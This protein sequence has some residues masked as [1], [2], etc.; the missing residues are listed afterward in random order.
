MKKPPKAIPEKAPRDELE[1]IAFAVDDMLNGTRPPPR[2]FGYALFVFELGEP[3][4]GRV[5]YASN[6]QR[7]QMVGAVRQWL[8]RAEAQAQEIGIGMTDD[9]SSLFPASP[10]AK[11]RAD[12]AAIGGL[13]NELVS[14]PAGPVRAMIEEGERLEAKLR[15]AK[16]PAELH[17]RLC[18]NPVEIVGDRLHCRTCGFNSTMFHLAPLV[19]GR[20]V[21]S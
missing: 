3:F 1:V 2:R 16:R 20:K 8:A 14:V 5:A 15:E 10:W 4:G 17:G 12:L 7:S 18:Q 6:G 9:D 11:W 13:E 19:G 21:A